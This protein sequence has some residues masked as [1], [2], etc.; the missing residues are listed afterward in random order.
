MLMVDVLRSVCLYSLS[1]FAANK[2]IYLHEYSSL[3]QTT[4]E[5]NYKIRSIII[6][7]IIIIIIII[8][9]LT[10]LIVSDI[11]NRST[12]CGLVLPDFATVLYHIA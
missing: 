5:L 2:R 10:L 6:V 9:L 11:H 12:N 8:L 3:R 4:Y 1:A 7:V